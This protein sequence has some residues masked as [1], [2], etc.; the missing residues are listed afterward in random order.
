MISRRLVNGGQQA[1]VTFCLPRA[2]ANGR[3]AVVGDFNDWDPSATRMRKR[4]PTLIATVTLPAGRRYAFLYLC[5]DGAWLNDP[6][7]DAYVGNQFGSDNG[8]LDLRS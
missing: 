3:M 8:I 5:E 7:A 6:E 4:G 1:E 2:A